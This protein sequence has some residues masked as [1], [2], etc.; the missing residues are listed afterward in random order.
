MKFDGFIR[1]VKRLII[2]VIKNDFFGMAAEMGFMMVIGIF[3]FM[4]FLMAVF[5]WM[6]NKALM[7][8]VLRFLATFM[9]EQAMD[10][11]LTVLSEVMIFSQGGVM[12]IVGFCVTMFLSTNAI[13]VVL[14]GLNR[15]YKVTETRNLIYTRVLSLIMVFVDT[16]VMFLTIN[17]IIFGKAIINLMVDHFHMSHG[18]AITLLT[19][20][21]PVAFAALYLMAFLSYYILPDLRGNEKF[22][23]ESALPGT[24]F[25]CTFWLIGSWGFSL[26]VNNLRTYNMVY[27]TIG[28]FAVLMVWFYYTSILILIGGEINSQV[29]NK[30]ESKAN[31]IKASFAKL[32][33]F[34]M[35]TED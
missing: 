6:G 4:L 20:R 9:P 1:A 19:L 8:P 29:Y 31:E 13:A 22:K 15:A 23:R 30:L 18:I 35:D 11:I 24:W 17:L 7:G 14:K 10:L 26:Y 33:K 32:E 21:W 25:F 27:G 28:A 2:S 16:M 5:G 34:N 3:P 12:A